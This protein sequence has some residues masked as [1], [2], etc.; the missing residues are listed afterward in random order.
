MTRCGLFRKVYDVIS[1]DLILSYGNCWK[2][3]LWR[4]HLNQQR[5]VRLFIV[6][7]ILVLYSGLD[8]ADTWQQSGLFGITTEYSTNPTLVPANQTGVWQSILAPGY[9]L[10]RLGESYVLNAGVALQVVR[11]SN[12]A[13]I[14]DRND[15]SAFVGWNRQTDTAQFGITAKYSKTSTLVSDISITGPR[16]FDSTSASRMMSGSWSQK[17]SERSTL[18]VDGTYEGVSYSSTAYTDYSTRS[19]NLMFKYDW[20][21]FSSPYLKIS[22]VDYEPANGFVN[23]SSHSA[24]TALGLNWE[25][26]ENL[27]GTMQVGKSKDSSAGMSTQGLVSVQYTGQ[28]TGLVLNASRQDMPTGLGSSITVDQANANWSYALSEINKCGIDLGRQ[29]NHYINETTYS[30]SGA[31]LRHEINPYWGMRTYYTHRNS[32]Q[33][34]IGGAYSDTVGIVLTYTDSDL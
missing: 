34:G 15:P 28:R 33:I 1:T 13:L 8:W 27:K 5:F 25:A 10:K 30:N 3:K 20:S 31:W 22:Y 6:P 14:Q 23:V 17:L 4:N 16:L 2:Q 21:E 26:T 19:G 7:I 12:K 9:M 11:S 29:K 32:S 18:S 24:N